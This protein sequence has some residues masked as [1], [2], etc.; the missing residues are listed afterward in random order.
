MFII[1]KNTKLERSARIFERVIFYTDVEKWSQDEKASVA[2]GGF[3]GSKQVVGSLREH[4]AKVW[5]Q[6][7][8]MLYR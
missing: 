1:Y 4:A 2:W 8:D 6:A 7:K 3:I 5:K